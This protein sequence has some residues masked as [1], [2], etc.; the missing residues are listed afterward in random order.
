MAPFGLHILFSPSLSISLF[1][2][3]FSSCRKPVVPGGDSSCDSLRMSSDVM[4]PKASYDVTH[5][6]IH[7]HQAGSDFVL[8][9]VAHV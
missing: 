6:V 3:L 5:H 2:F 8:Q 7:V 9:Q 1:S 4:V